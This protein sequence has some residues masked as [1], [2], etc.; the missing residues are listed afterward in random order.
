[1][2]CGPCLRFGTMPT[3]RAS[4]GMS[5][6]GL[7]DVIHELSPFWGP[8]W[9]ALPRKIASTTLTGFLGCA[10]IGAWRFSFC[11]AEAIPQSDGF[12]PLPCL[13][14]GRGCR[15]EFFLVCCAVLLPGGHL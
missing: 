10:L 11:A 1:M 5:P 8:C 4:P 14:C 9:L 15:P 12:A 7:L 3:D 13:R 6:R 2:L